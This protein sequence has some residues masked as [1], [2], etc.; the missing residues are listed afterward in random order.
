MRG[1]LLHVLL[2]R[3]FTGKIYPVSRTLKIA[4]GLKAYP[5]LADIPEPVDLVILV[6]PAEAAPDL[7]DECGKL[8]IKAVMVVA[9]GFSEEASDA[10][11]ARHKRLVE[12]ARKYD[13]ALMGPNTTGFV[14]TA[15]SL[16]ATFSP[17]VENK[18]LVLS[19]SVAP[20]A[21]IGVTSQS[22]GFTFAF[23]NRSQQR[24][25][26]YSIMVSSGNEA[27]LEGSDYVDFMLDDGATDIVLMYMEGVKQPER[28]KEVAIKAANRGKPLIVAKTGRSEAGKR[29]AASHTGALAGEARSFDAMLRDY[30]IIRGDDIDQMLDTAIAFSYCP[31][32]AGGRVGLVS[33]SGGGAVWM[34]ETL[35]AHGLEIIPFDPGTQSQLKALL[36]AYG[37]AQNPIDLTATAIRDVGYARIIEIVEQ[38]ETV[39]MIVVVGSLAYEYGIEADREALKRVIATCKKPVAFCTYTTASSRAIELLAEVGIPVF[40]SMPNC[41]RAMKTLA[42]YAEFQKRWARDRAV[43]TAKP[44]PTARDRAARTKLLADGPVFCEADA[45]DILGL[46]GIARPPERLVQNERDGVAAAHEVGYPVA[47]KAQSSAIAHKT[48][49]GAV[50]LNLASDAALTAAY[51]TMMERIANTPSTAMR[52]MLVQKMA[53]SGVEVI[54]GVNRDPLL[55]PMLLVG[56]GGVLVE[57]LDDIVITTVPVTR[58][59]AL[60]L[61]KSLRGARLFAGVR[62]R[63]PCDINALAALI[64][65]VS[66]FAAAHA[67]IVKEIDLNPVIVHESGLSVVDALIVTGDG[68]DVNRMKTVLMRECLSCH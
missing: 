66:E 17:S 42:D 30:G 4:Q 21:R 43:I 40:T 27:V 12:T 7:V 39:D 46:Y 36:P 59:R 15:T 50:A 56:F 67:D 3:E 51:R 1:R 49:A 35:V 41:A 13:I 47:L 37:S 64:T 34:T 54:I 2:Q 8:G 24:Q 31:L 32:P 28:F 19:P 16:A 29:A 52:G 5:T 48:E 22:G 45:K 23:I 44:A 25:I 9:S 10:A 63:P 6:T 65:A 58:D 11:Q 20:R 55:G 57:V 38:C 62:G 61:L 60:E 14:N 53:P 18:S 26:A 33:A 68:V